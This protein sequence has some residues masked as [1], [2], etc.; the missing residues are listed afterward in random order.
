VPKIVITMLLTLVLC[1]CD[2]PFDLV[3]KKGNTYLLNKVIG[4]VYLVDDT[5]LIELAEIYSTDKQTGRVITEK[6]TIKDQ[7]LAVNIRVKLLSDQV[8]YIL[9]ASPVTVKKM[10]EGKYR[11]VKEDFEWYINLANKNGSNKHIT[12][13]LKD[14][15]GF[16]LFEREVKVNAG[17][18]Y[19]G[20][21]EG[22]RSA[23]IY[24]GR[25]PLS[26]EL[27][28]YVSYMDIT[29]AL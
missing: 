4:T 6:F 19:V 15:E 16:L 24:E 23:V 3:E 25:F 2:A 12:I 20:D 21:D 5:N 27:V 14:M 1:G 10:Q 8:L 29:W 22:K 26:P 18:V 11:E 28:Q 13:Q 9:V 7:K 17:P